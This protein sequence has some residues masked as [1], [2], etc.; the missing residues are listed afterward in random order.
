LKRTEEGRERGDSQSR[1]NL[2]YVKVLHSS[3]LSLSPSLQIVSNVRVLFFVTT[4]SPEKCHD[5][6]VPVIDY[7]QC[8]GPVITITAC[9]LS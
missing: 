3:L 4:I 1:M 9:E 8:Q 6:G 5:L 7:K 2:E